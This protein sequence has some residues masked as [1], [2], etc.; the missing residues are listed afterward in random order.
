MAEPVEKL[1]TIR[2]GSAEILVAEHVFYNPVQEFNRD[3]SICVLATFSRVWQRER[4][5]ARRKKAKDGPAEDEVVEL[6]AG[7]RCDQG[8]RI[9]EALSA[10]GLRSVR[11]ANEIPGVKE[12]VANDLSKS[13]V[14]SIEN[15]VRH[16]KLEHL[17]TPSFN[18][19]M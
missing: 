11:Y 13:A 19:A 16:N 8:L 9:L 7:Q 6:V 2:E 5:E 12:I 10:T 18:D 17:I 14:E 4:A 1:K 3:L 15:S